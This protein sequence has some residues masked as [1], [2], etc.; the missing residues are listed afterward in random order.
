[1]EVEKMSGLEPDECKL[2]SGERV[3]IHLFRPQDAPGIGRL[4]HAVYADKYPFSRFYNPEELI[5]AFE[6]GDNYSIVARREDGE[7]I[8][9]LGF[10]RSAPFAGLYEAGAGLALPE[11][12]K[13]G[14]LLSLLHYT[15]GRLAM[16]LGIDEAWGEAVCNHLHMQRVMG[17]FDFLETGLEIDLM[18]EETYAKEGR[19]SGRVTSAVAFRCY[20]PSPHAVHLP[21]V[22]EKVL[23]SIYSWLDAR[24]TL[25][26]SGDLPPAGSS[27]CASHKVFDFAQVARIEVMAAGEDFEAWLKGAEAGILEGKIKVIQVRLNLSCPWV[28]SAVDILRRQGYFFGA[29]LPRWYGE[30]GLLMQKTI[31]RPGWENIMLFS[32]RARELLEIIRNDQEDVLSLQTGQ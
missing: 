4:F 28:G 14:L 17:R 18:P 32:D 13:E 31:D 11:F 22:Y 24:R 21:S 5:R 16:A 27:T 20:V 23:R 29:L 15:Y 8:A 10:F 30:D 3:F 26:V 9:H 7:I 1:M 6:T 12:R 19:S 25:H 2:S